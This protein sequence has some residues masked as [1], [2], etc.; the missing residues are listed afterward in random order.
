MKN[1]YK[2]LATLAVFAAV[3][4]PSNTHAYT[5]DPCSSSNPYWNGASIVN[6]G[7]HENYSKSENSLIYEITDLKMNGDILEVY[8]WAFESL[9]DTYLDGSHSQ[10]SFAFY[11]EGEFGNTEEYVPLF[12]NYASEGNVDGLKF[13]D[14]TYWNCYKKRQKDGAWMCMDQ[15]GDSSGNL[16]GWTTPTHR[17]GFKAFIDLKEAYE[18]GKL[19]KN[20]DY[21]LRLF[22]QRG[23]NKMR[24]ID[25]SIFK[26]LVD[27]SVLSYTGFESSDGSEALDIK[28]SGFKDTA[29]VI[30]SDGIV[31]GSSGF[32]CNSPFTGTVKYRYDARFNVGD[33]VI[34]SYRGPSGS[35][36]INLYE[37]SIGKVSGGKVG[38]GTAYKTYAPAS[39]INFDGTI[40]IST[41]TE[42]KIEEPE[43]C[44]GEEVYHFYYLFLAGLDNSTNGWMYNSAA[45]TNFGD[46]DIMKMLG[47][48]SN[49]EIIK[50]GGELRITN[51]NLDWYYEHLKKAQQ[52]G[53]NG[54]R[55]VQEGNNYFISYKSWCDTDANGNANNC[56]D[57]ETG[58]KIVDGKVTNDCPAN[59]LNGSFSIE[60]YKNNTVDLD[61][62]PGGGKPITISRQ[63]DASGLGY[64]F[65]INRYFEAYPTGRPSMRNPGMKVMSDQQHPAVYE[66]VWC[67][68][69]DVESECPDT[70]NQAQCNSS[71]TG[72]EF[73]FNEHD[74]KTTCTLPHDNRSGFVAIETGETREFCS[75]A[76]KEDLHGYLPATKNTAAGQ[77]FLLDN[78]IPKIEAKRTCVTSDIKY[79]EFKS[80][81]EGK[82]PGLKDA[83]NKYRDWYRY[84]IDRALT[85]THETINKPGGQL[86]CAD[87]NG[88]IYN[89]DYPSYSYVEWTVKPSDT[90]PNGFLNLGEIKEIPRDQIKG[91]DCDGPIKSDGRT[92][93]EY[94][95]EVK[96]TTEGMKAA[97]DAA[98]EDYSDLFVKYNKCFNWTDRTNDTQT[99]GG[100]GGIEPPLGIRGPVTGDHTSEYLYTFEPTVC[101]DYPDKDGSIFPVEYC[102][103]YGTRDVDMEGFDRNNQYWPHGSTPDNKY[104]NSSG[105][106]DNE[107][108]YY[109]NCGV[110]ADTC[111][112]KKDPIILYKNAAV[113]RDEEVKYTYHLPDVFTSVP[114]G[115]VTTTPSAG[116]TFLQ[117]DPESVPV[118]INTPAGIYNYSIRITDL[119]D[120]LRKKKEPNNPDDDWDTRFNGAT[121]T[122]GVDSALNA[123]DDYVCNYKVVNDIYLPGPKKFNFF[124]RVV[125]TYEINPLGRELGYNWTDGR[126]STV[127]EKIREDSLSY[128]TLTNVDDSPD[129]EKFVFTLDPVTMRSIR[130]YNA[131]KNMTSDGYADW[132]LVCAD[133]DQNVSGT[134]GYHCTSNFLTCLA[135]GPGSNC[136]SIVGEGHDNGEY[137]Y[138]ELLKNRQRLIQK[139][140]N[141]DCNSGHLPEACGS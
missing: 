60:K 75:M 100:G 40:T 3:F 61:K 64:N 139:Q 18:S 69:K 53:T 52:G 89:Y 54:N 121:Q 130:H 21:V 36:T 74:D 7:S 12:V 25:A 119:K 105:G 136:T 79:D 108:S 99:F 107:N 98:L 37:L 132:D 38:P 66:L 62:P 22:F 88:N 49:T 23:G 20:K 113:R 104:E 94:Q 92:L 42:E 110:S 29:R 135:D 2:F 83:Y 81:K 112:E 85:G 47:V 138:Q 72:S 102:Y 13:Y 19:K 32:A 134:S 65:S 50:V 33:N 103:K 77:Y 34:Q 118:N 30:Y 43:A 58:C 128:S 5:K 51:K 17:G 27:D 35:R 131:E 63:D 129:R 14:Y 106:L 125:D 28:I 46:S 24:T 141:L 80:Q 96:D 56:F 10:V 73:I 59:K 82:E 91:Y 55:Y 57:A 11:P 140:N 116:G 6:F 76:C 48:N 111:E 101:F 133:Y 90:S 87:E 109:F 86:S 26:G 1:R 114:S 84:Y 123:G 45:G 16:H 137:D 127:Q 31:L 15:P 44:E 4:S 41:K 115:R 68:G 97:Y 120:D 9:Y 8:G 70:V 117:L 93:E 78:Y 124:Y 67:K 122:P 71:D 39:W 126:G 95:N